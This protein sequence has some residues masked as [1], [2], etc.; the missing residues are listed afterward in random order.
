MILAHLFAHVS[1]S[2]N[3]VLER[4]RASAVSTFKFRIL[5]AVNG[6]LRRQK[7][8][9]CHSRPAVSSL[10]L[11]IECCASILNLLCDKALV[12]LVNRF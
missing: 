2:H 7:F 6:H 4:A 11:P 3:A 10:Y 9:T 12:Q 1:L 5:L 8:S